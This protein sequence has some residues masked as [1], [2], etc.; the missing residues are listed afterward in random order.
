MYSA[1]SL[2][3]IEITELIS[4]HLQRKINVI[5]HLAAHGEVFSLK[6]LYIFISIIDPIMGLSGPLHSIQPIYLHWWSPFPYT[7]IPINSLIYSLPE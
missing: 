5:Q 4:A 2:F 1:H 3:T 6:N 7:C